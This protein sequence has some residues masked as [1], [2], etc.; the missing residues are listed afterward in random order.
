M[1]CGLSDL[2]GRKL[3]SHCRQ[4]ESGTI[5]M[6]FDTVPRDWIKQERLAALD[7]SRGSWRGRVRHQYVDAIRGDLNNDLLSARSGV[8]IDHRGRPASRRARGSR[9]ARRTLTTVRDPRYGTVRFELS[10]VAGEN[11]R[12]RPSSRQW[13]GPLVTRD[14]ARIGGRL[15]DRDTGQRHRGI[16]DVDFT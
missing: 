3:L 6:T 10:P 9:F 13:C 8:A 7:H 4:G 5:M 11:R 15:A 1:S 14:I 2:G 16:D 12:S